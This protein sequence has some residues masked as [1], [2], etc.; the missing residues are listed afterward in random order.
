MFGFAF[1]VDKINNV[2]FVNAFFLIFYVS[3]KDRSCQFNTRALVLKVSR[4]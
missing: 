3:V 4:P 1:F 2:C